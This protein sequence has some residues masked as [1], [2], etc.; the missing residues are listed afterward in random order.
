V[1]NLLVVEFLIGR[2]LASPRERVTDG[3][4]RG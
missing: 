1:P 2:S 3:G 4:S